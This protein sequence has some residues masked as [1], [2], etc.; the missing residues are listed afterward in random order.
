MR[1]REKGRRLPDIDVLARG[2]LRRGLGE[3]PDAAR[4][5]ADIAD[6]ESMSAWEL[7]DLAKRMGVDHAAMIRSLEQEDDERWMYSH[8]NPG[9]EGELEFDLVLELLGRR[10]TRKAKIVYTHTPDWEYWD[11]LKHAPYTGWGGSTWRIKL[12][13]VPQEQD[14]EGN[15]IDL[16]SYWMDLEELTRDDIIPTEVWDV[17][18][19]AVD[20]K[21]RIEDAERRRVAAARAA[22]PKPTRRRH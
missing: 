18:L 10:V 1:Q 19:D 8:R 6:I 11:Q 13:A 4:H 21:C 16:K 2:F 20:D 17:L 12:Q 15:W 5:V 14:D 7:L 22:S 9:F 3:H